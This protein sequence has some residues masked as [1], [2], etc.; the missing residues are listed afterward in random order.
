M[1]KM[2]V[3]IAAFVAICF[4]SAGAAGAASVA[5]SGDAL[6]NAVSDKT[7][8]LKNFRFRIADTLFLAR[9][10]DRPH[11]HFRRGLLR[12]Q[13]RVRPRQVVGGRPEALPGMVQL[14]GRRDL[15]LR[16]KRAGTE[17]GALGSQ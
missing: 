13:E 1:L 14:D 16:A 4:A 2:T 5:L 7:V 6:R 17:Q 3:K 8:L 10:H 11:E 12:Q 15:L 9:D